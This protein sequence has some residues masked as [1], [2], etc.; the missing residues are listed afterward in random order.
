MGPPKLRDNFHVHYYHSAII[1]VKNKYIC[2]ITK[3]VR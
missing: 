1:A 3:I 2:N